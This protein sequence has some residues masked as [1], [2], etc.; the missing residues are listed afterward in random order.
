MAKPSTPATTTLKST[1]LSNCAPPVEVAFGAPLVLVLLLSAVCVC[2]SGV[3]VCLLPPEAGETNSVGELSPVAIF[4]ED[5]CATVIGEDTLAKS[6]ALGVVLMDVGVFPS[7]V[8]ATV[9]VAV[10]RGRLGVDSEQ[11]GVMPMDIVASGM[12]NPG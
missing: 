4:A 12:E 2:L 5:V 8:L 1:T 11:L 7:D 6:V 9:A 10:G 3:F